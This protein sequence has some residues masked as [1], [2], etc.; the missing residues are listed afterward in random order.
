MGETASDIQTN[1]AEKGK[2]LEAD[3]VDTGQEV[4]NKEGGDGS[5]NHYLV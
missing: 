4:P 3:V 2:C 5:F 1:E